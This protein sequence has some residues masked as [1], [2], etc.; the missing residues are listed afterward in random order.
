MDR[1]YRLHQRM[2]RSRFPGLARL[3]HLYLR[4]VYGC[5]IWGET[6]IGENARFP[7]SALGVVLHPN[8]R[9]G[10]DC[11]ICQLVTVGGRGDRSLPVI[12][13]RV[14]IGAGAIVIGDVTVGDDAVIG[15]G[16]VVLSD[17][18]SGAMVVGNPARI[19]ETR[20]GGD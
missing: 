3:I 19:V 11:V 18:P 15:A 2:R 16:A 1:V 12:G 14:F 6:Q 5:D 8:A 4:G 17:V 7:H 13:D 20:H 9:I 10:R